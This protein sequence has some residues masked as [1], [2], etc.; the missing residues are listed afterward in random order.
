[1]FGYVLVRV[2]GEESDKPVFETAFAIGRTFA[3]HL[4]FLHVG[5]NVEQLL[6]AV[7]FGETAHG[8]SVNDAIE[9]LQQGAAQQR[10]RAEQMVRGFCADKG[11]TLVGQAV[12]QAVSAAW[13]ADAGSEAAVL[14]MHAR[15]ADLF[16]MGR[17]RESGQVAMDVIK[18][19]LIETGRPMLLAPAVPPPQI[20]RRVAIAWKDTREAA[21][22]V[23][24]A[25][26][27]IQRAEHVTIL[28]VVEDDWTDEGSH[29][30]LCH[31]L[32]WHNR[33]TV[34]RRIDRGT[35]HAAEKL[36]VEAT[37]EGADL[38]VMGGYSHSRLRETLFGGVTQ[39]ILRGADLPVLMAH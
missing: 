26:P 25:L 8:T 27:F 15:A 9:R 2:S 18:T 7:I 6:L 22:A 12:D 21:R 34:V 35:E 10:A 13:R 17:K 39:R 30:H 37:A 28:C 4:A 11:L 33:N 5:I 24:A 14:T 20:G 1:M 19:A 23:A 32:S 38:L 16:V 29:T 3:A 31:D 36:L